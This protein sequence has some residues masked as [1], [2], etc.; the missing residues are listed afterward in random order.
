[1]FSSPSK[2]FV[3]GCKQQKLLL[4]KH[5]T[6]SKFLACCTSSSRCTST[7][8]PRRLSSGNACKIVFTTFQ[9]SG[10]M[11]GWKT[12]HGVDA[13][14]GMALAAVENVQSSAAS[15]SPFRC[16]LDKA[17]ANTM[18]TNRCV[19]TCKNGV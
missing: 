4:E 8:V 5:T 14:M 6:L 7:R 18:L 17:P 15:Q 9:G 11:P 10:L 16:Q 12:I 13:F 1:M 19:P 3:W 2:T